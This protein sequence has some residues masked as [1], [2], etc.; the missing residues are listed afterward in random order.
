MEPLLFLKHF[1]LSLKIILPIFL[2]SSANGII[3]I[4]CIVLYIMQ[5][6]SL[7]AVM[8]RIF[9]IFQNLN[10]MILIK[11][12]CLLY[13]NQ[14]AGL[15]GV[16]HSPPIL[17]QNT[18]SVKI[19]DFL[20]DQWYIAV[21]RYFYHRTRVMC[22]FVFW[23]WINTLI[24]FRKRDICVRYFVEVI[25]LKL[26]LMK[27]LQKVM[28]ALWILL[29]KKTQKCLKTGREG[30]C[31]CMHGSCF[32]RRLVKVIVGSVKDMYCCINSLF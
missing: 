32:M 6:L 4:A 14:A 28:C 7:S 3:D 23:L 15:I 11:N 25:G 19:E 24:Y 18:S 9:L 20:F 26:M 22:T 12:G 1:A 29:M 8:L 16:R 21:T 31:R 30:L 10:H 17:V 2:I 27:N 13:Q 5:Q